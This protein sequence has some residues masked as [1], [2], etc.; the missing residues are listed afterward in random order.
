MSRRV[1]NI[2]KGDKVLLS[3]KN[4]IE[5]KLDKL[6]IGAFKVQDVK[7]TTAHLRLLSTGIFPKFYISLFKKAPEQV[8]LVKN[9]HY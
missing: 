3:I 6:Y 4:L 7:G 5:R 9:W 2:K 1:Y 8:L